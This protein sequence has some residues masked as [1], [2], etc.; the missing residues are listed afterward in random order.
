MHPSVARTGIVG[1]NGRWNALAPFVRRNT[2]TARQ[3]GTYWANTAALFRSARRSKSAN[4]ARPAQTREVRPI[5]TD[6]VPKRGWVRANSGGSSP[7]S[8]RAARGRGARPGAAGGETNDRG[9]Q[10][11]AAKRPPPGRAHAPPA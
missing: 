7:V 3:V 6:G 9:T 8:P 2:G 10:T 5:A 4:T 1:P 11:D